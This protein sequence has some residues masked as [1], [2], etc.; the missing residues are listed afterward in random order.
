MMGEIHDGEEEMGL[1]D[2]AIDIL[3]ANRERGDG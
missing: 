1:M 3:I 2:R